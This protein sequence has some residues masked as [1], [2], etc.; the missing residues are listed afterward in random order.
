MKLLFIYPDMVS[1]DPTWSG[2]YYEGIATLSAAA[3]AAG[4]DCELLHVHHDLPEEDIV[5]WVRVNQAEQGGTLICFS[6]TTNQFHYVKRWAPALKRHFDFPTLVGG[7][8]PTLSPDDAIAQAGIDM[9]CKGDGEVPL[10]LLATALEEGK[11]AADVPGIWWKDEQGTVHKGPPA[12]LAN[13][14]EQPTP[15]W[16]IYHHFRG[17]MVIREQVGILMGSRGCPYD[18]AYCCNI[19]LVEDAKGQGK[20]VRFKDVPRFIEEIKT[21][22]ARFPFIQA[23]FFED[24]IFGVSK[25][26]LKEFAPVYKREIGKP[27][28]CNMRPNLVDDW[29]VDTLAEAGCVRVHMAI[30]AGNEGVRNAILN[31]RL[32]NEKLVE[33]FLKFKR[34]GIQV[35][36][37]NIVGSPHET[38]E[39]VLETIK[40]NARIDPDFMQHS[41][42]YPYEGTPLYDLVTKEGLWAKGR[43]VTDY[44]ADT[45]LEQASITREQ[46]LMFQ[47]NFKELVKLYQRVERLPEPV[48]RLARGAS[49]RFLAW[50]GAP[51]VVGLLRKR[52]KARPG[53]DKRDQAAA[54]MEVAC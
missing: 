17:L 12:P 24:D 46:V 13:L 5:S 21:Y 18:C 19:A 49:D 22:Q 53:R 34:K 3:K 44:F 2:Y 27:F 14:N 29:M 30:E 36:S 16:D 15:D 54:A 1:P 20:F 40:L 32:S 9:I 50:S 25:R 52:A 23:F 4:H 10:A 41:I 43:D 8:H 37:Y 7:M 38:P 35:M 31:R 33:S 39:A 11:G 48:R 28:G 26:W 51:R 45:A 42:F 6:A 47:Q